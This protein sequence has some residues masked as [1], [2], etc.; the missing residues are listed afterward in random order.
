MTS[1]EFDSSETSCINRVAIIECLECRWGKEREHLDSQLAH[2]QLSV[3]NLA[4]Y[5]DKN[6]LPKMVKIVDE[7]TIFEKSYLG[8]P[9]WLAE[10]VSRN[11]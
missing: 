10:V 9:K 8:R 1:K 2:A 7:M 11:G 3:H 4:H 6:I 5:K